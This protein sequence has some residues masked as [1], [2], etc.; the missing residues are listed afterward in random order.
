[1]PT[2]SMSSCTVA[3]RGGVLCS[4]MSVTT[5]ACAATSAPVATIQPATAPAWRRHVTSA[6]QPAAATKTPL[7]TP[8]PSDGTVDADGGDHH[9]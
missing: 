6:V 9:A 2:A 1:M 4:A 5:R 8:S 7:T 3:P